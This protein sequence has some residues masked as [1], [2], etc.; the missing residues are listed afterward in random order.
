MNLH[1]GTKHMT[2]DSLAQ[3][4]FFFFPAKQKRQ[5]LSPIQIP[6]PYVLQPLVQE[7]LIVLIGLK[8]KSKERSP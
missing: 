8:A 3:L 7:E 6:Y 4:F 1:L 5:Y 2:L